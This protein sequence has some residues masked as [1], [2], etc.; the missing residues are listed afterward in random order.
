MS[1]YGNFLQMCEKNSLFL[2]H[3]NN[4]IQY[5][6]ELY[7]MFLTKKY[8]IWISSLHFQKKKT[9][10]TKQPGSC[11]L[12]WPPLI[13]LSGL[14]AADGWFS[15]G[16][17][18]ACL[19]LAVSFHSCIS[20]LFVSLFSP[21]LSPSAHPVLSFDKLFSTWMTQM[22]SASHPLDSLPW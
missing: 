7:S 4:W 21:L 11:V 2:A 13:K 3:K 16:E 1:P 10:T 5:I 8:K 22:T 12:M 6:Y 14:T 19:C 18:A 20:H 9:T 17:Q 15:V